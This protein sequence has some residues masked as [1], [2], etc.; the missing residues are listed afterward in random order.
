MSRRL[1]TLYQLMAG[2]S[3]TFTGLLLIFAPGLTLRLMGVLSSPQPVV[4]ASFI[5][6]FVLSVGLTYFFVIRSWPLTPGNAAR[7]KTQWQVTALVRASVALVLLA[8]LALHRMEIAWV[9][10]AVTDGALASAQWLGLSRG[11]FDHA[12]E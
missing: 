10:V 8:E 4:Y 6:A 11:W 7:W 5:G 12:S 2:L 1:L 3:D 9:T